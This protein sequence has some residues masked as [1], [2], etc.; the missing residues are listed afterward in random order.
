MQDILYLKEGAEFRR[1]EKISTVPTNIILALEPSA[2]DK[3][4]KTESETN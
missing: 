2:A 3:P 1:S 4:E